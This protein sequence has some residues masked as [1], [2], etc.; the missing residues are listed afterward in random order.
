VTELYL[1][2][3]GV[4]SHTG[5]RLTGWAPGVPLSEDGRREAETAAR[6]LRGVK[7]KAVYSSPIDR[8]LETARLVAAPHDLEVVVRD[9]LGEVDYGKWTNRSLRS[10]ARTKLWLQLRS[11]PSNTRFPGG[12]TLRETQ[13]RALA[14]IDRICSDHPRGAVC[15]VTHADVIRAVVAHFLGLH[16]DLIER[17]TIGPASITL[18]AVAAFGP[19]VI[20]VN[21]PPNSFKG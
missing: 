2:R 8:T 17:I 1:V 12:E 19:R 11:W 16:L 21:A 5:H 6:A 10:V 4:T 18:I 15:C 20:T 7:F 9:G 3:H 13:V 14:E